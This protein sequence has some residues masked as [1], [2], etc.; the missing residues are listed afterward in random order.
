MEILLVLI[1]SR[2]SNEKIYFYIKTYEKSVVNNVNLG[3]EN[4]DIK[5]EVVIH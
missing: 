3:K 2:Y 5:K 1:D 4:N